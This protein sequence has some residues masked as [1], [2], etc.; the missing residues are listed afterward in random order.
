VH[1]EADTAIDQLGTVLDELAALLQ[2]LKTAHAAVAGYQQHNG[3][4]LQLD[5]LA[6]SLTTT[7]DMVATTSLDLEDA[8]AVIDDDEPV[9]DRYGTGT[10]WA[11]PQRPRYVLSLAERAAEGTAEATTTYRQ[12]L[13]D[14]ALTE[15]MDPTCP[16]LADGRPCGTQRVRRADG[17]RAAACWPHLTAAQKQEI[18][19]ERQTATAAHDCTQCGAPAGQRC[20]DDRGQR[21]TIHHRRLQL[22]KPA[23]S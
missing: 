10:R 17:T 13:S 21:T 14:R 9:A 5:E 11:G 23:H 12:R 1:E 8:A 3:R 4:L 18:T 20:V 7:H 16:K 6:A 19:A 22:L 2:R 15:A